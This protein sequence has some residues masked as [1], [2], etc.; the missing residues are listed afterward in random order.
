MEKHYQNYML[1]EMYLKYKDRNRLNITVEKN[2]CQDNTCQKKATEIQKY[3]FQKKPISTSDQGH[4]R[5]KISGM[6]K[7][8]L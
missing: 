1:Q 4:F 2:T 6:E 8:T 7:V 3:S 5:A